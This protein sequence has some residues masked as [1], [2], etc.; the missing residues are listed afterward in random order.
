MFEENKKTLKVEN[1]VVKMPTA[2]GVSR[3]SPIQVL[4]RRDDA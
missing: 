3:L 2:P 4:P 1:E